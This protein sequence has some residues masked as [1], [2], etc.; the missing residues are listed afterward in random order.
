MGLRFLV[1]L[2]LAGLVIACANVGLRE[3]APAGWWGW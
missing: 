2:L 3:I 1:A